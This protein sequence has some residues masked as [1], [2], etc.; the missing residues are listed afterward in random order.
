MQ[1]PTGKPGALTDRIFRCI[2]IE[3]CTQDAANAAILGVD[4]AESSHARDDGSNDSFLDNNDAAGCDGDDDEGRS[5]FSYIE[6]NNGGED[7]GED[8]EVA[9]ANSQSGSSVVDDVGHP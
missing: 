6:F 7:G 1:K 9:A 4:S 5:P 8:E 2:A 3:R